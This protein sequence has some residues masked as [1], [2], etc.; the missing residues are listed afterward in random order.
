MKDSKD[1]APL[2]VDSCF[3]GMAIYKYSVMGNCTY[4]HRSSSPP[5]ISDCE[6]VYYHECLRNRTKDIRI[7]SNPSMKLWY[8]H[9]SFEKISW[10]DTYLHILGWR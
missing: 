10:R 6:H 2:E 8:G 7:L 5:Y 4:S 3:G 9:S 1:A